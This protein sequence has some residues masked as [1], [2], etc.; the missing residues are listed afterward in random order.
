MSTYFLDIDSTCIIYG[1]IM[2]GGWG[3][4]RKWILIICI[5]C[6]FCPIYWSI[7]RRKY[8]FIDC[9]W[10]WGDMLVIFIVYHKYTL[11]GKMFST[12]YTL[13]VIFIIFFSAKWTFFHLLTNNDKFIPTDLQ[14]L[15]YPYS[16]YNQR[17]FYIIIY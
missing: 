12:I 17:F 4:C 13:S 6:R 3:W 7:C 1:I 10:C 8:I 11:D 5:R 15:H 2:C 16:T 14:G 9:W